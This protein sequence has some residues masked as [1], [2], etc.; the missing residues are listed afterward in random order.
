M[1]GRRA[2]QLYWMARY[3]ERAENMARLLDVTYRM[4]LIPQ[5][6]DARRSAW[7]SALLVAGDAEAFAETHDDVTRR[8]VFGHIALDPDHPNSIY[9]CIWLARENA[10]ALRAAIPTEMWEC[11]N[12]AWLEIQ[13][14]TPASLAVEGYR[15]FFDWVKERMILF[16]GTAEGTMMRDEGYGFA[17][18]GWDLERADNTA[19]LLDSKYHILLPESED[20]GG[21][22]DYYQWGAVLRSVGAFRAYHRI[23]RDVVTPYRVAE[24]LTLRRDMPRSLRACFERVEDTL[25]ELRGDTA[26]QEC[27]RL[28]G[29]IHARLRFG[30]MGEIFRSGLHEFLIEFLDSNRALGEQIERDFMMIQ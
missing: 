17:Q 9:A 6:D 13:E 22:V 3:T 20:V 11:L 21:A 14:M 10:R 15:G 25:Q 4:S 1:L 18:L 19:R 30:R 8:N 28:A 26:D 5:P 29:Q 27:G 23:Y 2:D 12:A 7:E 24:L 16:R